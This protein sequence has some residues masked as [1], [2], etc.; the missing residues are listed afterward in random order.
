[1][2]EFILSKI[3]TMIII[4]KTDNGN[5]KFVFALNSLVL[6]FFRYHHTAAVLNKRFICQ[7]L[8]LPSSKAGPP[9]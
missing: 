5:N 3:K 1:M 9:Q 2:I 4:A 8:N 7:A 6:S